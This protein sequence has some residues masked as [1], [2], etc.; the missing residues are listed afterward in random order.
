MKLRILGAAGAQ[1][2]KVASISALLGG[3]TL[4][5]AGTGAHHLT[6]EEMD[7][8]Q[9]VLITH[10]HLDHVTM[11]C[12]IAD[13]KIGS[14][15]GHGM[16]V[17]CLPETA[18]AIRTGLLNGKI[19]P[20]FEKIVVDGVP[21]M[22]FEYFRPFEKIDL[23]GGAV[24]IPFPVDHAD[25]PTVGFALQTKGE[26]FVFISDVRAM[27]DETY[28]FLHSLPNLRRMTIETSFPDGKEAV[29]R[30]S[31]HLT[32]SMLQEIV[33][34]LPKQAEIFYCHVKPR[35]DAEVGVQMAKRFGERVKGLRENMEFDI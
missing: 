25:V 1:C 14:P 20:N 18:D 6:L 12:F 22:S 7:E 9:D 33:D 4:I 10:S 27:S 15:K 11:L 34:R 19:W 26:S 29:A 35:Y 30:A 31:G 32:P 28:D 2:G 13:C 5:D 16:R 21:L 17:R 24:A 8:I 23:G 3:R